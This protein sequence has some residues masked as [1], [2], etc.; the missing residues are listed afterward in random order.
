VAEV[1][2]SRLAIAP[3]KGTRLST[4]ERIEL[5]LDGVREN[6]RF[7]LIDERNRMVNAKTLGALQ[8]VVA[9]YSD[10]D[11]RLALTF[12]DGGSVIDE[13][14]LGGE[15]HTR[16]YSGSVA[17]RLVEGP[18]SEL[19]SEHVGKPLR[20]VE[21]VQGGATDRIG[22]G[23]ASLIS[24]ASLDRL[25]SE[26]GT[27]ELDPRRFRMLIEVD[28]VAAN[29][30]DRWVGRRTRV[31]DAL[32][33][34]GGH[35]GRC[36]ITSRDPDTGEIDLPTLDLLGGYRG[37]VESTEPLPFGIY[38]RVVEPGTIAVGDALTLEG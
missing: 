23:P 25:A 10:A 12:P 14:T 4:V 32:I 36:L 21:P 18:W 38:G 22:K 26:A 31:G 30:E 3:V 2:V 8:T 24:R 19:L 5:G 20:L 34:W 35:V 15:V 27:A 28:G 9:N 29:H 37:A 7:Y 17:A 33:A 11:R 13:V 1:V 16:F 6:R